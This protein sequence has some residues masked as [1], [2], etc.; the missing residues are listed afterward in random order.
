[1]DRRSAFMHHKFAVVDGKA[2]WTGSANVTEN[3]MYRNDNN[4]ILL[5]ATPV[6]ANFVTEFEEMFLHKRFGG[7]SRADTP[8]PVLEMGAGRIETYFAPDDGV[9]AE[10]IA[11]VAAAS[12]SIDVMAFAFTSQPI[13]EAMAARLSTGVPV[14]LLLETRS[15]G[16]KYPRDDFLRQRG[17]HV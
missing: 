3:G 8:Y 12:V 14:R 5:R 1:L 9:A 13:A 16:G 2:V 17:A 11:E 10:I 7:A 15:S 6:A 4:A